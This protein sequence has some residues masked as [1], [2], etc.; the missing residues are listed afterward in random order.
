MAIIRRM[1][2]RVIF[3]MTVIAIIMM[4][5]GCSNAP[6]SLSS[7]NPTP[8]S[9]YETIDTGKIESETI[10]TEK[11]ETETI[12]RET[13]IPELKEVE[14][15]IS[16]QWDNNNSSIKL[17]SCQTYYLSQEKIENLNEIEGLTDE[18]TKNLEKIH[19]DGAEAAY[20][21]CL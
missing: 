13:T 20:A 9:I 14:K 4:T 17:D 11:T 16:Q 15:V 6:L 10:I 12:E 1:A 3:I 7:T 8:Q 18:V 5:S 21:S 2:E 19:K